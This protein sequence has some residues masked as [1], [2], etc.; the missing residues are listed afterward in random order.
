M[1]IDK[2]IGYMLIASVVSAFSGVSVKVLTQDISS[3]ET[4]FFR[5]LFGFIIILYLLY[6]NPPNTKGGFRLLLFT[7]GFLGIVG[8]V[9]FFYTLET[10]ALGTSITL[11]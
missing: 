11:N 6:K 2:G 4:V 7:R 1:I 10:I 9:A 3:I 5:N 8:I